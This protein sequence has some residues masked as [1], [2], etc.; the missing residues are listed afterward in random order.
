MT[1]NSQKTNKRAKLQKTV[2]KKKTTKRQ[3]KESPVGS[4]STSQIMEKAIVLAP[5]VERPS[6]VDLIRS[7]QRA[8]GNFD[9][10]GTA[11]GYCDQWGCRWRTFCLP[12]RKNEE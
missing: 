7:I 6:M 1:K 11:N 2:V 4:S 12:S 9:C 10:F 8:E 3:T 5:L